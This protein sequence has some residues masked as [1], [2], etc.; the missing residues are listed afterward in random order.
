MKKPSDTTARAWARLARAHRIALSSIEGALKNAGLPSLA[1][2]DVLL[3]LE[4]AG[5]DGLRPF[6]LERELLLPQHGV[7]RLVGRI[8]NAGH[9]KRKTCADDGRGQRLVI[10]TAGRKI[11]R[12][13]WSIYGQAIEDA[14]GAKLSSKQVRDLS[15]ILAKLISRRSV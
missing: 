12:H 2:Y 6:E 14:V 9:L 4:R 13:M 15:G 8:E 11:R 10:T 7:S 1:W 5:K 3:E